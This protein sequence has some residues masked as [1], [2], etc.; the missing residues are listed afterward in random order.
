MAD[1]HQRVRACNGQIGGFRPSR[2]AGILRHAASVPTAAFGDA[3]LDDALGFVRFG[4]SG[5]A[6]DTRSGKNTV[7][8]A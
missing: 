7:P 6:R 1:H 4:V 5:A 8:S 3:E 2:A